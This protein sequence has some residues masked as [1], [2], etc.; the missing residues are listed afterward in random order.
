M[1]SETIFYL[2]MVSEKKSIDIKT[3][4]QAKWMVDDI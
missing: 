3:Q 1:K 4:D 2:L